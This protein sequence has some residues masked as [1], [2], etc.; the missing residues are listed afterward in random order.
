ML[1]ASVL[2][3][4]DAPDEWQSS[5]AD[6]DLGGAHSRWGAFEA[7]PPASI[8]FADVPWPSSAATLLRSL[9]AA[10]RRGDA[11]QEAG[12]PQTQR[13]QK[14]D[15]AERL[16]AGCTAGV[17]V[18]GD[19][20][21][22]AFLIASRRWHPDKFEARFGRYLAASERAAIMGAVQALMQGINEAAASQPD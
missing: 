8:R 18:T 20:W 2:K 5:L 13:R 19:S 1:S 22:A 9:A 14:A 10:V 11:L 6:P 15:M 4:D 3:D 12:D 16:R 17:T 21:R 7:V